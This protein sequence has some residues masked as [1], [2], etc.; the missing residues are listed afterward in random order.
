[1]AFAIAACI[2]GLIKWLAWYFNVQGDEDSAPNGVDTRAREGA[3]ERKTAKRA[4]VD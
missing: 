2:T 1:V 3:S 4:K